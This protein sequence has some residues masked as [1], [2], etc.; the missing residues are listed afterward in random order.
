MPQPADIYTALAVGYDV[1]MA[2]VDY[3]YW[4]EYVYKIIQKH[5][6]ATKTLLELGCGTG[7]L[8]LELQPLGGFNYLGTDRS[9]EMLF[10]AR[11]KAEAFGV[12]VEF[13]EADFT[14]YRVDPPV[15]AIVLVYDGMNYLLEE[16]EVR[17]LLRCSYA[18][19]KPGGIFVFDQSTP[20][21]SVNNTAAF[22]DEGGEGPFHFVR[23]S[24]YDPQKRL[25]TTELTLTVQEEQFVETH[26]ERAYTLDE[27]RALVAETDFDMLAAY[28]DFSQRPASERTER[29]HWVLRRA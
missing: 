17:A 3:E 24:R 18:A 9:S 26:V 28:H 1:V 16:E 2:H 4:A 27:I 20:A 7:N 21:N 13:A 22:N 5:H 12:P 6:P 14:N 8:A 19:L 11:S 29:V 10:V 25:H 23:R 15:D